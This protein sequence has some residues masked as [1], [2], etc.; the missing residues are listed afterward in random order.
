M[1][2]TDYHDIA[3]ELAARLG[4]NYTFGVRFVE[5]SAVW[6]S[7]EPPH[8]DPEKRNFAASRT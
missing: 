8:A 5:L 7:Q 4:M 2:R 3:A 6:L 1:R